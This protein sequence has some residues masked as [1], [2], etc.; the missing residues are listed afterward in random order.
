MG[1]HPLTHFSKYYLF[2]SFFFFF[3]TTALRILPDFSKLTYELIGHFC[4]AEEQRL[5]LLVLSWGIYLSDGVGSFR[6]CSVEQKFSY[7]IQPNTAATPITS[8]PGWPCTSTPSSCI[9]ILTCLTFV[10]SKRS[11]VGTG[12]LGRGVQYTKEFKVPALLTSLGTVSIQNRRWIDIW[13]WG[14][15]QDKLSL[16]ISICCCTPSWTVF[17][18][19]FSCRWT[20]LLPQP[21]F[22]L[23]NDSGTKSIPRL[24]RSGVRTSPPL[25]LL[26]HSLGPFPSLLPQ[27]KPGN[28]SRGYKRRERPAS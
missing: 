14:R 28:A 19:S 6:T 18:W 20:T 4:C 3:S 23:R 9:F 5:F 21:S 2:L 10:E 13:V 22:L 16:Q 27:Q 17:V 25:F 7:W 11:R 26:S 8:L 1:L 12:D 15:M 24:A